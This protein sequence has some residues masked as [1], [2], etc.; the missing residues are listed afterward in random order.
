M[1]P[2]DRELFRI[3]LLRILDA[4]DTRFGL[5]AEACSTLVQ[6][7]GFNSP[8]DRAELELEYLADESRALVTLTSKTISKENRTWRITQA[9][10]A[11][12]D[13]HGY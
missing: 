9:G 1:T 12:L 4:N 8:P 11:F 2:A 3:C 13:D 5:G 10:R 7:F 6:R